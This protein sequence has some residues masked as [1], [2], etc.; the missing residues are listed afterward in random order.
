VAR[1]SVSLMQNLVVSL[2]FAAIISPSNAAAQERSQTCGGLEINVVSLTRTGPG[3]VTADFLLRNTKNDDMGMFVYYGG[4]NGRNTFL[5][6]DSGTEW[7]K[8]RIDG[9][10]NHRQALLAGVKTKYRLIFHVA[11]GGQD[12]RVFQ[13]NAWVQ[14]L[15]LVGMARPDTSGWCQFKFAGLPLSV[16]P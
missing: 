8:K 5:I 6:D 15:P 4:S 3:D 14:L 11:S 16:A 10:G 2:I 7:P 13:L 12:A 9:N 1:A